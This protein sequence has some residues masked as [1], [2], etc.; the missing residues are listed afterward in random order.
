MFVE[1]EAVRSAADAVIARTGAVLFVLHCSRIYWAVVP[2]VSPKAARRQEPKPCE[3]SGFSRFSS[4]PGPRWSPW[5]PTS[6]PESA[7]LR[8]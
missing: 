3:S 8:A 6:V 5:S 2:R 4:L 7:P 1:R